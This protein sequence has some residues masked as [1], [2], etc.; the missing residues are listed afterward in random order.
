MPKFKKGSKEARDFMAKLR[1]KRGKTATKKAAPKKK[2]IGTTQGNLFAP[3]PKR[4]QSGTSNLEADK[5]RKAKAPGK[6]KT[7]SGG[8]YY[9]SRRNRSDI[10]GT[11]AGIGAITTD[12]KRKLIA[13]QKH[14]SAL[15]GQLAQTIELGKQTRSK[16]YKAQA[17]VIRKKITEARKLVAR[18]KRVAK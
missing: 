12:L 2:R 14:L 3:S 15:V 18:L 4:K 8:T 9:E 13:T 1:A 5:R 11:M 7:A 16:T 17:V 10:P 6:R